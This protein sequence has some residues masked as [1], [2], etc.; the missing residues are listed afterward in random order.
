MIIGIL[1]AD[2]LD[3]DVIERYG[4]YADT[5]EQ[6]LSAVD[7]QLAFQTYHV[8]QQQYPQDINDCDVYLITGSKSSVYEDIDWIN[9]L[10][11]FVVDCYER[12]V[13]MVGICFGHQLIAHALGGRVQKSDKG[14]GIGV[15]SSEVT[16]MPDWL[17]PEK[18]QFNL[19]VSHQ[20]QVTR[21][22]QQASLVATN[23]F[24]P[25]AGYRVN[26]SILTFQGHPEFSRDYLRY[27]MT[28][29]RDLI[30]EQAYNHAKQSLAR[31]LN[32]DNNLVAQ[33]IVNFIRK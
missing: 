12:E 24:C 20:D 17:V 33:W 32:E 14:W 18:K 26:N 3:D 2:I 30:G 10:K 31:A 5:F 29:R 1:E 22:P 4:H 9:R 13:K 8:T 21:L 28:H 11:Q 6:L 27:I 23:E 25:I 15:A 7:P 16:H 19:L